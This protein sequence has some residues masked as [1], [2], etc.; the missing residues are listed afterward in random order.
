MAIPDWVTPPEYTA[1][2]A[3]V[4]R[5]GANDLSLRVVRVTA[6]IQV[7]LLSA[8]VLLSSYWRFPASESLS[9][10]VADGWCDGD[11]EGIATHC[12]GDFGYQLANARLADPWS[13][14]LNPYPPSV[15]VLFDGFRILEGA[16]GYNFSLAIYM[17]TLVVSVGATCRLVCRRTALGRQDP[18]AVSIAV[19][20]GWGLI[21]ALDRGN[22]V[23]WLM[24]LAVM[25]LAP[26]AR[27]DRLQWWAVVMLALVK[28][29]FL[30]VG[31]SFGLFA[32]V[33][34]AL[35]FGAV[36]VLATTLLLGPSRLVEGLR[37]WVSSVISNDDY[38]IGLG[39]NSSLD[40]A[41]ETISQALPA[42][43]FIELVSDVVSRIP[44]GF[45]FAASYLAL[46]LTS[47][48]RR[49]SGSGPSFEMI[50]LGMIVAVMT[51]VIVF[52]YYAVVVQILALMWLDSKGR[53]KVGADE[54]LSRPPLQVP[55]I[56][57]LFVLS[58]ITIVDPS[59]NRHLSVVLLP[60]AAL[61]FIPYMILRP[62]TWTG[63]S[64]PNGS[65]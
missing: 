10:P 30:V 39:Q 1:G 62:L 41:A 21:S 57:V 54:V 35:M 6:V 18:V 31:A 53:V 60:L 13:A 52:P 22:N 34:M 9:F 64:L 65:E 4:P 3:D 32:L 5:H 45:V 26:G 11:S 17:L 59:S 42:W 55:L 25:L 7:V 28:P 56:T 14:G 33:R 48:R 2:G 44:I 49:A 20:L 61:V 27:R 15:Y 8:L 58:S 46:A 47:S 38:P 19:L 29:Q 43:R 36:Q 12:F 40:S 51:P 63:Q 37:S 23:V 50:A 16:L 24:P